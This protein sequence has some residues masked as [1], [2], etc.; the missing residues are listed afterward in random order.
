MSTKST[1]WY[2]EQLHLYQ[3]AFDVENVYLDI[4]TQS[5]YLE[6]VTIK[7]PLS[8]W[9]EMRK[10]TIQP[11]ERYSDLSNEEMLAEAA[12]AVDE[13]RARLEAAPDGPFK[14][15]AGAFLFDSPESERAEMIDHFLR[16]YRPELAKGQA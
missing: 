9:K 2:S 10:Q 11:A 13:Q 7:I 6:Q 4:E 12:R 14:Q 3:D 8:S 15:L 1:L 16:V 5:P